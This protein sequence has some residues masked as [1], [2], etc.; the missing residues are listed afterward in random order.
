VALDKRTGKVRWKKPRAGYQAY[1]TPL[2][3]PVNGRDQM[4]SPGAHRAIS[5]EPA[6]G[7][8][9][10]SVAYGKGY[11]NVPRP[12]FGHGLVYICTGFDQPSLLAVRPG[13]KGD[14]TATHV[15]WETKRGAPLTPSPL[16]V[17]DELYFVSDNG[18]A[19]CL[20]ARTG[21]EHW[22][23]RL[24]GNYSASP[25]YADGRIYFLSEDCEA[26]VIAPGKEFRLLTRNRLD[27]RCL[28][29]LAISGSAIFVRSDTALY[30]LEQQSPSQ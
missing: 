24:G 23:Q 15:A 21:A 7:E 20:D 26:P 8:E 30:R 19:S 13:G 16:L 3:V 2:I 6:T 17:G 28:A 11:S 1:T 5:Y 12:V 22:R 27:G 4:V 9:I 18:I 25:V 14:V 10:W 29:S